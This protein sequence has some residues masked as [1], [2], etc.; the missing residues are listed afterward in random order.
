MFVT[1]NVYAIVLPTVLPDGVPAVLSIVS[2]GDEV[3]VTVALSA[4]E[5][6]VPPIGSSA[7]AVA[8]LVIE[9]ASMSC[10]VTT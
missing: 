6:V 3:I 4:G 5:V 9:L 7:V 2:A 10:W 1:R 8:V